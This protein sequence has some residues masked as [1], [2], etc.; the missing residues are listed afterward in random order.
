M[1]S[2]SDSGDVLDLERDLPTTA[3]DV[4][5][6]NRLRYGRSLTFE[7]YVGASRLSVRRRQRACGPAGLRAGRRSI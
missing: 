2:S 5:V 7:Q 4:A 3:E 6:L 1:T